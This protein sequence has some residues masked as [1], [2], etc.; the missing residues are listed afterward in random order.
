MRK[1][2][3]H[4][5]NYLRTGYEEN[6]ITPEDYISS[7]AEYDDQGNI[8]SE[9]SYSPDATLQSATVTEYDDNHHPLLLKNYD[10]EGVLCEQISSVYENGRLVEQTQCY[11]EGMPEYTTRMVYENDRLVRRDCYDDGEFSYTE[12]ALSY[13]EKGQLI[14]DVEYDEDGQE[15]YVTVN[16]YDENGRLINRV[17]DEVQQ[18]DRRSAAFEYDERGNKIK[19]LIYNYEETLIAKIYY[20]YDEENRLIEEEEED[21]DHYRKTCYE[22][23]GEKPVK[24]SV[25]DKDGNLQSWTAYT[26]DESGRIQTQDSYANDEVNPAV[27]RLMNHVDYTRE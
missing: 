22:Y 15:M 18:K 21:L 14:K 13:N 19:D 17:R 5:I 11:G 7:I 10:G 4:T 1:L 2:T 24:I 8:I 20:R 23:E 9:N 27:C 26:Y 6:D 12:R 3:I 25:F 16:E